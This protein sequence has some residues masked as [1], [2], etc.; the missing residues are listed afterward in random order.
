M[1]G[2]ELNSFAA[3]RFIRSNVFS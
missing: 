3:P 1:K 2:A